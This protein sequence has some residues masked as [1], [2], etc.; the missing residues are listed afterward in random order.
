MLTLVPVVA[1]CQFSFSSGGPDYK[2]LESAI[3]DELNKQYSSMS[4][5]VSSVECPRPSSSPKAGSSFTCI[6]D[7]DGNDVRV[8]VKFTDD[9]YN[10]DFA[11][12]DVVFDLTETEKGL[13]QDISQDYG[14]NVKVNCGSGLKVV[15]VGESFECE[16]VD[17]RGDTRPVKVT[18][19]GPDNDDTWEVIGGN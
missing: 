14:F 3:T 15:P 12:L 18:A 8:E 2:K 1:G 7:L 11:T 19:G 9:D 10:V 13:S 4:E 17:G 16:A 6:A 5:Q